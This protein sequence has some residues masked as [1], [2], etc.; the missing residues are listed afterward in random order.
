[1]QTTFGMFRKYTFKVQCG[2]P[3]GFSMQKCFLS[4]LEKWKNVVDEKEVFGALLTGMSLVKLV[5]SC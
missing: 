5:M 4:V 3:K 1:M 2:F